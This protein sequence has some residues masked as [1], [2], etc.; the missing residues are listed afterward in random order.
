MAYAPDLAKTLVEDAAAVGQAYRDA[1]PLSV[2]PPPPPPSMAAPMPS[3]PKVP[4]APASPAMPPIRPVPEAMKQSPAATPL[5]T[6]Q[7]RPK[8]SPIIRRPDDRPAM[9]DIQVPSK[10]TGPVDELRVL[11]LTVFV[12]SALIPKAVA[13][14]VENR[15]AR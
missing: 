1:T 5:P 14:V 13:R 6:P 8:P 4:N 7:Y 10:M 15:I 9:S 12:D 11:T 2:T 3:R